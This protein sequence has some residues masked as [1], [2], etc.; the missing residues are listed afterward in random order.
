[1]PEESLLQCLRDDPVVLLLHVGDERVEQA[2][3]LLAHRAEADALTDADH[4][5]VHVGSDHR[6][7]HHV[8]VVG[9]DLLRDVGDGRRVFPEPTKMRRVSPRSYILA[10]AIAAL[11][12]STRPYAEHLL[13]LA[14]GEVDD[15]RGTASPRRPVRMFVPDSPPNSAGM[16]AVTR[17]A[18]SRRSI[19]CGVM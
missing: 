8:L 6:V 4:Q 2:T 12:S 7:G 13:G 14:D 18:R 1:M 11:F 15:G 19:V 17:W 10:S 3:G 5:R 16:P 9:E